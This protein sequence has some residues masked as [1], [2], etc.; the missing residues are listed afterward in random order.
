M[1]S[2]CSA[3][4]RL[5]MPWLSDKIGRRCTDVLLFAGLCGLSVWFWRA[6]GWWVLVVYSLLTFCYSGQA[7]VL[8]STVTDLFGPRH[9]GVNYGFAALGMSAGSVGFPLA[10]RLLNLTAGRH[11][12][13]IGAAAAGLVCLF[14]LKPTQGRRL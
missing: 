9:T 1:G 7:A 12:V 3:A 4:G 13:A 10:A 2:V 5:L 8:P 6:G 11:A 14:F